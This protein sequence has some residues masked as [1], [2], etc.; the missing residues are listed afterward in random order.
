[1]PIGSLFNRTLQVRRAG[2]TDLIAT[3]AAR[4]EPLSPEAQAISLEGGQLAHDFRAFTEIADIRRSD[5][6]TDPV[7][8]DKYEA[9]AVRDPG[10]AGHHLELDM[11]AVV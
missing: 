5:A 10:G 2:G 4:I 1:M 7:T 9:R 11:R 6:L 8:G 3:V